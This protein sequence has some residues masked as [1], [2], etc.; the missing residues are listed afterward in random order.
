[1][2]NDV[3]RPAMAFG[4]K[5]FLSALRSR[6]L[7]VLTVIVGTILVAGSGVLALA[8]V[9]TPT[10]GDEDG[11]EVPD[12]F[13]VWFAGTDGV[14][15][16]IAFGITPV[17]LPFLPILMASRNLQRDRERGVFEVSMTQPVPSWGP[18]LG[19]FAGLYGA[20]TIPT[21]AISLGCV[22]AIQLIA[23]APVDVGFAVAYVSGSV[24]LVG[25]Y[26][27]LTLMVGTLLAPEFVAPL[28]VLGWVGFHLLR[29]TGAFITARLM[30]I[31]GADQATTFQVQ[32]TD[33][34]TFT[35][36]HQGFLGPSVPA[37][38]E[39][40]MAPGAGGSVVTQAIPWAILAW[41]VS[42]FVLYAL[43]LRRTP[44]R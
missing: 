14:L 27:V 20:L 10:E 8:M 38:L 34:A 13:E 19:K 16:G 28:V 43:L 4:A 6:R 12:P 24:L 1:M 29:Q 42:L 11:G 22:L 7:L 44:N 21:V 2:L 3:L 5:D 40:V 35:G 41:L 36:L 17:V 25:L 32:W 31:V 23:A 26:L 33:L 18:A 15:T 37:G 30:T 9:N 39:F